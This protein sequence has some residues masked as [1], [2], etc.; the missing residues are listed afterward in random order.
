MASPAQVTANQQNALYSTGP[1]TDAGKEISS[2]NATTHGLTARK[3]V[4]SL[5]D[6]SEY[7][8]IRQAM[9]DAWNPKTAYERMLF[10]D[11]V[12][13]RWSWSRAQRTHTAVLE[14]ILQEEQKANPKLSADQALARVFTE[15]KNAKRMRLLMR[16]EASAE[17][18]YR[19]RFQELQRLT[20]ARAQMEAHR[21]ML[22][23]RQQGGAGG[24]A[25]EP[26]PAT[27][28][29]SVSQTAAPHRR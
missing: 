10:E 8:E 28:I 6:Q 21:R 12:R 18:A 26:L 3:F 24:S 16:Y 4:L 17:R 13:A 1:K 5:E 9:L 20:T 29:G 22:A 27:E 14:A 2:H 15:E 11:T 19:Q 25:C 23:N 7:D